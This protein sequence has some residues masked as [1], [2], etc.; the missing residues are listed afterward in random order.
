M[1]ISTRALP[2]LTDRWHLGLTARVTRWLT[3]LTVMYWHSLP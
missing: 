1:S 2:T 3:P